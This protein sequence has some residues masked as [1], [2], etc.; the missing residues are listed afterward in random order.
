M[1]LG[2]FFVLGFLCLIYIF[3][4]CFFILNQ[5]HQRFFSLNTVEGNRVAWRI[6]TAQYIFFPSWGIY[7]FLY[8]LSIE[9]TCVASEDVII[10]CNILA[11]LFAKNIFG[12]LLWDTLWNCLQGKW[13]TEEVGAGTEISMAQELEAGEPDPISAPA[14]VYPS[15]SVEGS[16]APGNMAVDKTVLIPLASI[17]ACL[18]FSFWTV[19]S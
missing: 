8:I 2:R 12:I 6:R 19:D 7:P 9:G 11:D 13:S 17:C 15:I 3:V 1:L 18:E 5:A 16:Q 10:V 14:I 4:V